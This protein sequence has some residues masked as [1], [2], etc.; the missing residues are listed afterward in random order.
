M[1]LL[2]RSDRRAVAPGH[3]EGPDGGAVQ[4]TGGGGGLVHAWY[5]PGLAIPFGA[6]R[7]RNR[8]LPRSIS[9]G[10]DVRG[11]RRTSSRDT[12]DQLSDGLGRGHRGVAGEYASP[13]AVREYVVE[14]HR[15]LVAGGEHGLGRQ[16]RH[17][18]YERFAEARI[19]GNELD[20]VCRLG[21][22]ASDEV[23]EDTVD[24]V[25]DLLGR[26]RRRTT[27]DATVPTGRAAPATAR[28]STEPRR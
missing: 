27:P 17:S 9:L 3:L 4:R 22:V 25:L 21:A 6:G 28:L 19:L 16:V 5:P 12:A 14:R 7:C 20:D 2:Y 10:L 15:H 11:A 23:V 13:G 18:R 1:C 24:E 8:F 26:G